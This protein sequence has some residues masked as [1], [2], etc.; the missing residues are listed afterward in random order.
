MFYKRSI[1]FIIIFSFI[2][3][4]SFTNNAKADDDIVEAYHAIKA[5]DTGERKATFFEILLNFLFASLER[6]NILDNPLIA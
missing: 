1:S 4:F 2:F 6:G 3:V 5:A